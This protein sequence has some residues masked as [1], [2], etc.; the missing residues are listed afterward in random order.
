MNALYTGELTPRL[1]VPD[2]IARLIFDGEPK[3]SRHP[4]R[5]HFER[6]DEE[7]QRGVIAYSEELD[8]LH[9]DLGFIAEELE[10]AVVVL[11]RRSLH[12]KRLAI[13][14][15]SDNLAFRVHAY[16]EK[17]FKL[18]NHFLRLKLV[19][20]PKQRGVSTDESLGFNDKVINMLGATKRP[21]L[22]TLLGMFRREKVLSQALEFRRLLAHG[23]AIREWDTITA[24]RRVDDQTFARSPAYELDRETDLD[25]LHRKVQKRFGAIQTRLEQFRRD[26]VLGL[27]RAVPRR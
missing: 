10:Q 2:E 25:R 21:E 5:L 26:L 20:R 14:C 17:V 22:A 11:Y 16:R 1:D 9:E 12:L 18:V 7:D 23:R 15:H 6:L 8:C 4:V 3:P 24:R 27:E 13:I 19:D